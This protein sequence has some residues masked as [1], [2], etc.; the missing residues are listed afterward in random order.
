MLQIVLGWGAADSSF[1][2]P[3]S[4]AVIGGLITSTVLNLL[5]VLAAFTYIANLAHG[6][7]RVASKVRRSRPA[8][9]TPAPPATHS[10]R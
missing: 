4:G 2:S 9:Q 6:F 8:K 3:M 10:P 1:R 5:L 7:K